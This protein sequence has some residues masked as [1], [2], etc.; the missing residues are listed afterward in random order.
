MVLFRE[1][2][3]FG[4]ANLLDTVY[5]IFLFLAMLAVSSLVVYNLYNENLPDILAGKRR[6]NEQTNECLYRLC[7][8][9]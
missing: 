3:E 6:K 1:F 8:S 7:E 9:I 4:S 5:P 2:V